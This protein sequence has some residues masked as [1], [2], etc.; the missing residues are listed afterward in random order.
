MFLIFMNCMKFHRQAKKNVHKVRGPVPIDFDEA[1]NQLIEENRVEE[2]KETIITFPIYRY[3]SL[4]EPP[5][6][7]LTQKEIKVIDDN[8]QK[9]SDMSGGEISYYSHDDKPW[10][11]SED[12]EELNYEAVFYRDSEYSVMVYSEDE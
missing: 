3:Q 10:R 9:F 6:T 2:I 12:N 1:K 11:L 7:N 4:V 8:I 5:L